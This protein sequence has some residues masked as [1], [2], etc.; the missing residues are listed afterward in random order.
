MVENWSKSNNRVGLNNRVEK[1]LKS[2]I[3][4]QARKRFITSFYADWFFSKINRVGPNKM[5]V[6][7][8]SWTKI[9]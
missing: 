6:Q 2:L 3:I 8:G 5:I 9:R 1:M 4:V 7:G